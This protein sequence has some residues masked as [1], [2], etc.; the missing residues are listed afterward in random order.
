MT[1]PQ[2]PDMAAAFALDALD[3]D[4]RE[5][6][7]AQLRSDPELQSLVEEYGDVVGT[8]AEELEP[9]TPPVELRERVLMRARANIADKSL[10]SL[11]AGPGESPRWPSRLA[12]AASVILAL[13]MGASALRL[14]QRAG[15]LEQV[16]ATLEGELE[17]IRLELQSAEVEL[18]RYDSIAATFVGQDLRFASLSAPD[19]DPALHL[20]HNQE[21]DLLLVAATNLPPAPTDRIYQL[22]GI[23]EGEDPVSLGTFNSDAQ[24]SALQTLGAAAA[25]EFDIAAVTDEPAGGSPQPTTTP[26]LVG[27]WTGGAS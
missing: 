7:E 16:V 13:V 10:R 26:F 20:I 22:W 12:I 8:M 23:R 15:G 9:L 27:S 5:A 25:P 2:W 21:Q 11:V 24:N 6:F 19:A 4:E 1:A 18:A 17:G 3:G 14:S